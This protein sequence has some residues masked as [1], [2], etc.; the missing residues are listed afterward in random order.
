MTPLHAQTHPTLD[1]EGCFGCRIASV[2]LA[3]S[4]T[5]SRNRGAESKA[6]AEREKRWTRDHAAYKRLWAE[7]LSPRHL[8]GAADLERDAKGK[9]DI[10]MFMGASAHVEEVSGD[11]A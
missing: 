9:A 5:P 2:N 3:P 1:V 11:A 6:N 4:A 10:E 7:G 8:D